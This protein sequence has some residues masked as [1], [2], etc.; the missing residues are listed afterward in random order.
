MQKYWLLDTEKLTDIK[1]SFFGYSIDKN[2]NIYFNE[3]PNEIDGTGC[4]TFIK[5]LNDK[6]TINQDFMG[7]QGIYHYKNVNYDIF[8]NAFEKL[9]DYLLTKKEKLTFDLKYATQYIFSNEEP[10]N[11]NDTLINEIKRLS[12]EIRVEI[13]LKGEVNFINIDYEMNSVLLNSKEAIQ[14]LDEW[15]IKW[16]KVFRNIGKNYS[17][18]LI[19]LSGGFD[20][21]M[22]FGILLNANINKNNIIIKRNIPHE[23]SYAKNLED[24]EISEEIIKAF[25][26]EDRSNILYYENI[27]NDENDYS[28]FEEFSNLIFG[29][30]K[31][32]DYSTPKFEKPIF[33]IVGNYGDRTHLSDFTAV[34]IYLNFKKMKFNNDMKEKDIEILKE[35]IDKNAEIIIN[36]YKE[37]NR[38]LFLGDFSFEY[39]YRFMGSKMTTKIF[40][41]DIM[42]SPFVDPLFH[43]IKIYIEGTKNYFALASVI[44]TRYFEQLLNFKFQTDIDFGPRIINE[45]ERNFAKQLCEKYP[46]QKLNFD[47]IKFENNFKFVKKYINKEKKI[48]ERLEDILNKGEK[49]FVKIFNK[50]Y[51]E[52]ALKALKE[53]SIKMQ[54]YLT[55]IV[56]ICLILNKLKI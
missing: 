54:N 46:L 53:E 32:C 6:I 34:Q 52:L 27:K 31:I 10:I 30:A 48:R 13:N 33:H 36:K 29:N 8:S 51:F 41:N 3:I 12:K 23:N 4:Y 15:Y 28:I 43:K 22:C 14:I 18:F 7:L 47:E 55:P 5:V 24:Y 2:G 37:K 44:F 38:E 56:S 42:I 45:E 35:M 9:V 20:S 26:F 11:L 40:N 17:P 16:V 49:K 25:N 19:D 39:L 1:T 50:D 21:R